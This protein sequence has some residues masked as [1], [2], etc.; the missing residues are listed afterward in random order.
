M[1]IL[2][3]PEDADPE[4]EDARLRP[5]VGERA[6]VIR[7]PGDAPD[8][9]VLKAPLQPKTGRMLHWHVSSSRVKRI[10]GL[11]GTPLRATGRVPAPED[12]DQ[13]WRAQSVEDPAPMPPRS[14][15]ALDQ[16]V[17]EPAQLPAR[18]PCELHRDRRNPGQRVYLVAVVTFPEVNGSFGR[19]ADGMDAEQDQAVVELEGDFADSEGIQR[20]GLIRVRWSSLVP[21]DEQGVIVQNGPGDRSQLQKAQWPREPRAAREAGHSCNL[22]LPRVETALAVAIQSVVPPELRQSLDAAD[23]WIRLCQIDR[24]DLV[25]VF[26]QEGGFTYVWQEDGSVIMGGCLMRLFRSSR[27]RATHRPG[28]GE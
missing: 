25:Q 26:I 2:A 8:T 4:N 13:R 20:N 10:V 6:A 18:L 19:L 27:R 14:V 16:V 1:I 24:H 7:A 22:P 17:G 5:Y 11:R 21:V 28:R 3:Y 15:R 12:V 23:M 9:V